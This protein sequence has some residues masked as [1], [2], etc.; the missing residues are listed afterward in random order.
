MKYRQIHEDL[1]EKKTAPSP[2][3]L[4]QSFSAQHWPD[5]ARRGPETESFHQQECCLPVAMADNLIFRFQSV[6]MSL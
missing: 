3:T 5:I 6:F 2:K 4:S 1:K